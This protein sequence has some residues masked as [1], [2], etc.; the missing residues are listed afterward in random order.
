MEAGCSPKWTWKNI[1]NRRGRDTDPPPPPPWFKQTFL[2]T[3][4][5]CYMYLRIHPTFQK[6]YFYRLYIY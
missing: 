4:F 2:K 3:L 5:Q 6:D 1:P